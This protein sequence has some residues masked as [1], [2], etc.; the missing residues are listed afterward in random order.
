[1]IISVAGGREVAGIDNQCPIKPTRN[2]LSQR[3][4]MAMIWKDTERLGD[5]IVGK[6]LACWHH[7]EDAIH[8]RGMNPMEMHGVRLAPA[9]LKMDD[10][11]IAN[12]CP[13][14]RPR[15]EAVVNPSGKL[16]PFGH[17]DLFILRYNHILPLQCPIRSSG[18]LP[19]VKGCQKLHRIHL[20][21]ARRRNRSR[22]E[23]RARRTDWDHLVT[24]DRRLANR[25]LALQLLGQAFHAGARPPRGNGQAG[26]SRNRQGS[27]LQ[28]PSSGKARPLR[29]LPRSLHLVAHYSP[30][31]S[32]S[33]CSNSYTLR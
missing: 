7:L 14:C 29:I 31:L 5:E 25:I 23:G 19:I 4:H 1:M 16:H 12:G 26:R 22:R 8:V 18:G 15:H 13:K 20:G 28:K 9:V 11:A 10:E 17:F 21:A 30:V 27:T 6:T 3:H 32:V 2:V 33:Q 24:N